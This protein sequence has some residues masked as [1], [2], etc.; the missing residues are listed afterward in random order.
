MKVGHSASMFC[1][2]SYYLTKNDFIEKMLNIPTDLGMPLMKQADKNLRNYWLFVR[3]RSFD[4]TVR[5]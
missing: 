2:L 3:K 4:Q 5:K 1:A